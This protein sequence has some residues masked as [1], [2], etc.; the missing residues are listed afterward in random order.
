MKVTVIPIVT[1]A[2]GTIAKGLLNSPEDFEIKGQLE[3]TQ[4]TALLRSV[5][6]EKSP[7]DLQVM[8]VTHTPVKTHQLTLVGKAPKIIII[9]I[10]TRMTKENT[11]IQNVPQKEPSPVTIDQ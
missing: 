5:N 2:L 10:P 9:I 8:A 6:T 4:T 7:G 11:L 3:T 1:V